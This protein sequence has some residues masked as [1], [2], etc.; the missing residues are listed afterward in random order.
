MFEVSRDADVRRQ[1]IYVRRTD[2]SRWITVDDGKM[3]GIVNVAEARLLV[4][5]LM[6]ET[7]RLSFQEEDEDA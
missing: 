2:G 7:M 5:A 3:L 1:E 6:E 4:E